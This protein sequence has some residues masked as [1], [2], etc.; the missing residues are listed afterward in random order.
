[1]GGTTRKDKRDEE[2]L[3]CLVCQWPMS[4]VCQC[5][6]CR[7]SSVVC[8]CWPVCEEAMWSGGSG[9]LDRGLHAGAQGLARHGAPSRD[10][11]ATRRVCALISPC[12]SAF[13]KAKTRQSQGRS[14]G[15]PRLASVPVIQERASSFRLPH[16]TNLTHT[17][18]WQRYSRPSPCVMVRFKVSD[19][20]LTAS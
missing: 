18:G 14:G 8:C 1:M 4:V 5:V 9:P 3:D 11:G 12:N 17:Q 13:M 7:P 20:V 19:V 2:V 6:V 15:P 10:R 16:C